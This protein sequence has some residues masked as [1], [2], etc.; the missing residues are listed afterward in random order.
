ME[1]AFGENR[2]KVGSVIIL[3]LFY[4]LDFMDK[5]KNKSI[6]HMETYDFSKSYT[7]LPHSE[8][9]RDFSKILQ[10]FYNRDGM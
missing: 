9:K 4:S 2:E 10:K 5:I 1:R 8:M 3:L 6:E 7:A